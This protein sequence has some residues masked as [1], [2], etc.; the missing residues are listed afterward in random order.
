MDVWSNANEYLD[1]NSVWMIENAREN[2]YFIEITQQLYSPPKPMMP[3]LRVSIPVVIGP[4]LIKIANTFNSITLTLRSKPQ[5]FLMVG[6]VIFHNIWSLRTWKIDEK[7]ALT[8]LQVVSS[9]IVNKYDYRKYISKRIYRSLTLVCRLD[10]KI[11]TQYLYLWP[12]FFR[13]FACFS[14]IKILTKIFMFS[15]TRT[16][17][18][19]IKLQ[20]QS[21]A[22]ILNLTQQMELPTI[23]ESITAFVMCKLFPRNDDSSGEISKCFA[24]TKNL[25]RPAI[26]TE[27]VKKIL[28]LS[29]KTVVHVR[30]LSHTIQ[31]YA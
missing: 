16:H 26:W 29:F 4:R 31:K 11:T 14:H 10:T 1:S 23:F 18:H 21:M 9:H 27:C 3:Q 19:E 8:A 12:S 22:L 5:Q 6:N 24:V 13:Y 28:L 7:Y 30:K 25:T 17:A 20:T 2:V 15:F